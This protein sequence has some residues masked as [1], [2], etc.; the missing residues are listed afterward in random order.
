MVLSC[1]AGMNDT[2]PM[3]LA[4]KAEFLLARTEVETEPFSEEEN[5]LAAA[6]W[7]DKNGA[8]I[9]NSSLGY[10][11][12]RYFTW[13]MDGKTSFV[14]KAAN[15]AASKGMLV[16]NAMGNDGSHDWKILG[17]P[18]DA[19]SVL[20]IGGINPETDFHENFASFGPT[21]DKRMKP[22]VSAYSTAI[23]AEKSKLE[24]AQGTSFS[25]PLVTGFA[26]CA[27]QTEKGKT[28]ME[29][30]NEIQKS[31]DLYPYFDYAHGYGVPQASYFFSKNPKSEKIPTFQFKE[32]SDTLHIMVNIATISKNANTDN[33]LFY[34][35]SNNNGE[36]LKYFVI[37]VYQEDVVKIPISDFSDKVVTVCYK[38]YTNEI[39]LK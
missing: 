22:N 23:V 1:I 4:T 12:N 13:E 16:V 28:N 15:M 37:D 26:A 31:G 38:G 14:V 36:I 24:K 8:Q 17:T 20:S 10:T 30:F 29:M 25:T 19:D 7:A 33:Y 18:A 21:A 34:K 35:I 32:I 5:W 9:I 39:E 3:G 6:E 11:Y 27:W 2:V